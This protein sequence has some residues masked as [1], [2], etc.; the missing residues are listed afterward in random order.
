MSDSVRAV[1]V[2]LF[3]CLAV[4]YGYVVLT[5][6]IWEQGSFWAHVAME[7]IVFALIG[8][9]MIVLNH[10]KGPIPKYLS[11]GI[12]VFGVCIALFGAAM[13]LADGRWPALQ[14]PGAVV[15][16]VSVTILSLVVIAM[17]I[18]PRLLMR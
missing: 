17:T 12:I 18:G 8:G 1:L 5:F 3:I 9:A 13:M 4:A 7:C 10:W 11:S 15:F 6:T 2:L 14:R 16:G